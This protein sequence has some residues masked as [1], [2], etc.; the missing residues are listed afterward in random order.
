MKKTSQHTLLMPAACIQSQPLIPGESSY[1]KHLPGNLTWILPPHYQ[2]DM[3]NADIEKHNI[4]MNIPVPHISR[5]HAFISPPKKLSDFGRNI[6]IYEIFVC[7][8]S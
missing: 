8:N 1:D 3:N 5:L 4:Y 7:K 2:L 6:E